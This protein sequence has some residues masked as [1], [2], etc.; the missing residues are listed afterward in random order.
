LAVGHLN[1]L[2]P[3]SADL[4]LL[5]R[6]VPDESQLL[7]FLSRLFAGT[8]STSLSLCDYC[9]VFMIL[10]KR[11]VDD[12]HCSMIIKSVPDLTDALRPHAS[13][14][15]FSVRIA[16]RPKRQELVLERT[17]VGPAG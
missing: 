14:H 4:G 3:D 16:A 1:L 2:L 9:S 11:A 13:E 15:G 8:A 7:K 12:N 6:G 5:D 17:E 10:L